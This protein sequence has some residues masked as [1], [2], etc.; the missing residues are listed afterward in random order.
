ML[1]QEVTYATTKKDM[2]QLQDIQIFRSA[3]TITTQ[4][5]PEDTVSSKRRRNWDILCALLPKSVQCH[6]TY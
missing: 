4:A 5:V 1:Q 3:L 6:T 2:G